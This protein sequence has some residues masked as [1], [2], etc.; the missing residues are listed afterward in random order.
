MHDVIII[1]GSFAG[2]SAALQL[3]RARRDVV[4]LDTGLPRN[5]FASAAHGLL[6]QEGRAPSDILDD[7]RRQM[8]AYATVTFR[9]VAA[10]GA[11][12]IDGGFSIRIE[13]GEAIEGA[14]L[15]LAHGIIDDLPPI[16][17]LA[18]CWGRTV[19]H[20]PY[21]HGYEVRDLRIGMLVG[22]GHETMAAR[23]YRDW[24]RDLTLF[25]NGRPLDAAV[26]DELAAL[27][28]RIVDSPVISLGHKDG[29]LERVVCNEG[30]VEL[31]AMFAHSETRFSTPVGLELGCKT[32]QGYIGPYFTVGDLHETSVAGVYAAGDVARPGHNLAYA[33]S[34]GAGAGAAVH[35][36]LV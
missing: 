6:G 23:L 30:A 15:V 4:V 9:Q 28:V 13:G 25:S 5:R 19:L 27:G 18:E 35:R 17:G 12:R 36:S 11:S 34:D 1:G 31:D 16:Q 20:C 22:E 14:R 2:L 24:S 21:C 10:V 26:R 7:A 3:G 33:I 32:T 8:R 29:K